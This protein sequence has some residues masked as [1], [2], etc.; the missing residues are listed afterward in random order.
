MARKVRKEV[1]AL[2]SL[3]TLFNKYAMK[4]RKQCNLAKDSGH[5]IEHKAQELLRET[6]FQFRYDYEKK[7]DSLGLNIYCGLS[8]FNKP[9]AGVQ[10]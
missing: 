6:F 2:L 1:R 9:K 10:K 8:A 7:L 3:Q 4:T 5:H